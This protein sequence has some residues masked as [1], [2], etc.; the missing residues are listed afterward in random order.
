MLVGGPTELM[1]TSFA[2]MV[3]MRGR[4]CRIQAGLCWPGW[5][6]RLLLL[7]S[8]GRSR[9]HFARRR[10]DQVNNPLT[11]PASV[12]NDSGARTARYNPLTLSNYPCCCS[13]LSNVKISQ[14]SCNGFQR[15]KVIGVIDGSL[16]RFSFELLSQTQIH[17]ST[18]K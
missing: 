2:I 5:L 4:R 9:A 18:R 13:S 15:F 6:W 17:S 1:G 14:F 7:S 10:L 16:D 11:M 3:M 12:W 8:F